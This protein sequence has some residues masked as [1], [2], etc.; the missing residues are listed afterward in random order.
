MKHLLSI[1]LLITMVA[2]SSDEDTLSQTLSY[3]NTFAIVDDPSDSVQHERYLLYRDYGVSIYFNDTVT[4]KPKGNDWKGNPVYAYETIDLN[5]TFSGYNN[6]VT[7]TYDYI[8]SPEEQMQSLRYVRRYLQRVSKPMRPFSIMLA[9]TLTVASNSNVDRP[10]Y[11]VGFRTLVFAQMKDITDTTVMDSQF[12]QV[13]RNMIF[14]RVKANREVCARFANSAIENAWYGKEWKQLNCPTLSKWLTTSWVLN[15]NTLYNEA[16]YTTYDN[17]DIIT[18]LTRIN[19]QGTSYVETYEEAL[20]IRKKMITEMGNYGFIRGWK[21]SGSYAP[22]DDTEDRG[23]FIQAILELGEIGFQARYGNS[24]LVMEKYKI[25][26]DF[27]TQELG[28]NLEYDG[29]LSE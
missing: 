21:Q 5:W 26:A 19:I 11:H 12:V 6:S 29:R 14:D 27:I 8:T 13:I 24:P 16:P 15:G 28:V 18:L 9:D 3:E 17:E 1:L 2:C 7:Y 23:Y 20:E 4:R 25:L 22:N 10:K